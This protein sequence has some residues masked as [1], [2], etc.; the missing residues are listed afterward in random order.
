[1]RVKNECSLTTDQQQTLSRRP[2]AP[3]PACKGL[4]PLP[5]GTAGGGC[6]RRSQRLAPDMGRGRIAAAPCQK[7]LLRGASGM[8]VLAVECQGS[9]WQS[10]LSPL[11]PRLYTYFGR[12]FWGERDFEEL[13][14]RAVIYFMHRFRRQ[15]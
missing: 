8:A 11:V 4:R 3:G 9:Q 7:P 6:E 1:M 2:P 14:Q 13:R 5:T 15:W 10:D 12:C